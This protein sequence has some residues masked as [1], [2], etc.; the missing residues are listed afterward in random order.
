MGIT[1]EQFG[2][3]G[4]D[5]AARVS[6]LVRSGVVVVPSIRKAM[7]GLLAMALC[8]LAARALAIPSGAVLTNKAYLNYNGLSSP[9]EATSSV[10]VAPTGPVQPVLTLLA[11][12]SGGKTY[13]FA[14]G[15]CSVPAHVLPA[16]GASSGGYSPPSLPGTLNASP[17]AAYSIGDPVLVSV[18]DPNRNKSPTV[19]DK[20]QA[21]VTANG[22]G[23]SEQITLTETGVNTGVFTGYVYTT[24]AAT[25]ANDCALSVEANSSL[26]VKYTDPLL[27]ADVQTQSVAVDP[28]GEVFNDVTGKPINGIVLSLVNVDASGPATVRGDGPAFARYPATVKSGSRVYDAAGVAYPVGNGQYQFPAV[29][30]GNY[31]I[32]V[33]KSAA[34]TASTRTDAQ[35]QALG[36]APGNGYALTAASRGKVF[37]LTQGAL[38]RIDIPLHPVTHQGGQQASASAVEFMQYSDQPGVGTQYAVEQSECAGGASNQIVALRNTQIPV[39]GIVSLAPTKAIDAGQPLFVKV[40]DP[41]GNVNPNV[42][43]QV[44]AQLTA[45]A[46]GDTEW[47]TLTETTPNSGVF[48]GYIQTTR[49]PNATVGNC[50][51][52][53]VTNS[54]I[55]VTYTDAFDHVDT[56][57]STV[58]VDPYGKVFSS[59]DGAPVSGVTVTLINDRT[60]KPARIL[61]DGPDFAAFP[62]PVVTGST[63][64]DAAGNQYAFPPGDYRFPLV[65]PGQYHLEVSTVPGD[66]AFPSAVPD[67]D[68]QRLPGAP[69]ALGP[70]SR[71]EAFTVPLGPAVN[72]DVPLDRRDGQVFITKQASTQTA[73]IGDFVQFK[74]TVQNRSTHGLSDSDV[75]D[76]LPKGFRF[77][78]G[79]LM[80]DGKQVADTQISPDGRTLHIALPEI[81]D[82]AIDVS[83]VTEVTSGATLGAETNIA[84]VAGPLIAASNTAR[85]TVTVTDDLFKEK[86]ILTGRVTLGKCGTRDPHAK[87]VP[88]VRIFLEDGTNVTTDKNGMWH[89]DGVTPG[90]HV[91][92][93]DTDSLPKRYEVASCNTGPRFAGT[94]YSQFVDLQGGTVWRADFKVTQ[95]P[96]PTSTVK[97]TQSLEVQAGGIQ[98]TVRATNHGHVAVKD[99][100]VIYNTPHGW[101][102]KKG[103]EKLDGQASAPSQTIVG[104]LWRIDQLSGTDTLTF[105]LVPATP[106]AVT[107]LE[108]D[109]LKGVS[110][111]RL[112]FE[113]VGSPHGMTSVNRLPLAQLASGFDKLSTTVST[114]AVGSWDLLT[115]NATKPLPPRSPDVEGLININNGT[116]L[117]RRISAVKLD[118][119]SRL[120]PKLILDGKT[121]PAKRIGFKM[122]EPKTGKTLY[123]YIG[124]DFG[125]P[126]V[127]VLRLEGLDQFGIARFKQKVKVVRVGEL[128]RIKVLSTKGNVADGNTPVKVKLGLFDRAGQRINIPYKLILKGGDLHAYDKNMD[129]SQLTRIQNDNYVEVSA[130]GILRFNPVEHSGVYH[131]TL[132]YKDYDK[133][134]R[135]FVEPQKRKWIMVGLAQGTAA[136]REIAGNMRNLKGAGLADRYELHGRVAFYAKGVVKGKYVLT[137]AYDTA[138]KTPMAL[139]QSIDPNAYYTLYG[140]RTVVQHDAPSQS[141][142]YLKLERNQFYALFGDFSTGLTETDL[143][144]Y[145]RRFN[146]LKTEYQGKHIKVNAFAAE[147]NQ[148]FV[149]DQIRGD[150]TSGIYQLS[151]KN[152]VPDSETITIETR[153]RFHSQDILKKQRLQ[154]YLDYSIDYQN[155]TIFFK[156]P[157]YS[158]DSAFNPIYIVARYEVQGNGKNRLN[159]GGRV[160]YK[161]KPGSE[162]GVTLVR[163]GE[164]NKQANLAGADFRY[165]LNASTKVKAE[166]ATT[167][168]NDN[169]VVTSGSAFLAQISKH[170]S[171][172]YGKAYIRQEGLGFG[173]GQQSASESGTR[174]IGAQA[175]YRMNKKVDVRGEAYRQTDL[176]SGASENVASTTMT[177]VGKAYQ[178]NSG[179][180]TARSNVGGNQTS[181]QFIAGGSYQLLHGKMRLSSD[182]D[183][184]IGGKNGEV[185]FPRK[186]RV[187]LDYKLNKNVTLKAEQEFTW[188]NQ[189][190]SRAARVGVSSNLWKGAQLSE[191]LQQTYGE[192]AQRLAAVTGLQQSW[193]VNPHLRLD[194]GL[195]QSKTMGNSG[196]AP[197]PS[198]PGMSV[199]PLTVTTIY[200]SPD[201]NDF[202]SVTFGSR[203]QED[204]WDWSTRVEY[205][206]ATTDSRFNMLSDVIHNLHKGK[207]LLA[208]V[209][210]ERDDTGG[211][212]S[213]R[214]D[215]QLGYSYRPIDS[216]WTLFNKL[217]LTHSLSK[218][219][220]FDTLTQKIVNNLNANYLISPS[221][222]LALQYGL[223]YVTDNF[224]MSQYSGFTTL[225]GLQL[226]HD[227][228]ARWDVG[229]Q[230]SFYNSNSAGTSNHSYGLS[231]G[232][233]LAHNVWMSVGYNFTGFS[234]RD[235]SASGYTAKGIYLKYRVKFD[236]N[237]MRGLRNWGRH[238]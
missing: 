234:D 189:Q 229:A 26:T 14:P 184:P 169:G 215:I 62:N 33:F 25:G 9:L 52:N 106:G 159:V 177:Y 71:G 210:Y 166:V 22:T 11:P 179:L 15:A 90:T 158:E 20:V 161:F 96:P 42:R 63:V 121:I 153:D 191:Q 190:N 199:P 152:I 237:S 207:Q 40:N 219:T 233:N 165:R 175:D 176:Q 142:L 51:L 238:W 174:K 115:D 30:A 103:S 12:D 170:S 228:N 86:A 231:V 73:A 223:K 18:N 146:G 123:S 47:I 200:S 168:S 7:A 226:F 68:L 61:G 23:D 212:N 105:D 74:I 185:N 154:R 57:Q 193:T 136:Y 182:L 79:S 84:T 196:S 2:N 201:N 8:L 31:R 225:Y 192:N 127:H 1:I 56:S 28:F 118:L 181:N 108:P 48:I 46:T 131:A 126:G 221:T 38:P 230:G 78:Q 65:P 107:Q 130:N 89:I 202:T 149:R 58:L 44:T 82:K 157:I 113:S 110:L 197:K 141:K 150:G 178:L 67:A 5:N 117:S 69:Y 72:V 195:D 99:A 188:G 217:A 203:F 129:L 132:A 156:R 75:V 6:R 208:K 205:R 70:G 59:F 151:S 77:K 29:P 10:T 41:S 37:H 172:L 187:G 162:V 164:E 111:V 102:I 167:R 54:V 53:V 120:T 180:R 216:R 13:T 16:Q 206:K 98:V 125:D 214:T 85:A 49:G 224:D 143:S 24:S 112:G 209:V 17:A 124:V 218:T 194:F 100:D 147:A 95:R 145:S 186:L 81:S 235:F 27:P 139:G 220:Q 21:T 122:V 4:G 211:T 144:R 34:Y 198:T 137:A 134:L 128:Y 232:Y 204:A 227:L 133:K 83:Y 236:Q 94:P 213:T 173:L 19:R 97:L 55:H 50:K 87:G 104:A 160:A 60:G 140:D 32:E 3:P 148:A 91:V 45:P 163:Q 64:T 116:R 114:K 39:P 92:Q 101:Q 66:Y 171:K 183:T 93:L 80:V 222:Q 36:G 135:V 119:D 76:T 43:D 138:K 155:G 109:R 35:L 88:G